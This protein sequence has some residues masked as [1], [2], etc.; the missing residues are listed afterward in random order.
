MDV[1]GSI[2]APNYEKMK[3]MAINITS[4]FEISP[5][6]T[7]VGWINFND[8]AWVVFD[9]DTYTDKNSLHQAIDSIEYVDGGTDIGGALFE[10]YNVSFTSARSHLDVPHIGIVVTDGQSDFLRIQQA[11]MLINEERRIDMYAV[12]IGDYT[13]R[14]KQLLEIAKAGTA[15]EPSRNVFTV[16]NFET[17]GLQ[18]LQEVL[19]AR[20][21]FSKLFMK[22]GTFVMVTCTFST[23]KDSR[24]IKAAIEDL[25]NHSRSVSEGVTSYINTE[26]P[27]EGLTIN[28]CGKMGKVVFY[29]SKT[30]PTPN[31]ADYDEII[32]VEENICADT[33][34]NC[35]TDEETGRRRRQ[36]VSPERIFIGIEGVEET[37]EYE[38]NANT[39]DTS[40]P[41]GIVYFYLCSFCLQ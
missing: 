26:C 24:F 39:G 4:D 21:C 18:Q 29:I 11:S 36:A 32:V 8:D 2:T 22:N 17:E 13:T 41:K 30:T 3:Q 27:P 6:H 35:T 34:V 31:S 9:L 28:V 38:V 14:T 33:F 16:P 23:L 15:I 20:A 40:T 37:N 1:S 12:G 25:Q 19:K 7:R 5:N 10:L